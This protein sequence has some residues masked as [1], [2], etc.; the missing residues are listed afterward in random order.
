MLYN[1]SECEVRRR[2]TYVVDEGSPGALDTA[3]NGGQHP[4]RRVDDLPG[5]T[6]PVVHGVRLLLRLEARAPLVTEKG[7]RN[8]CV[9]SLKGDINPINV[10]KRVRTFTC[11]RGIYYFLYLID[12][13]KLFV[14][15]RNLNAFSFYLTRTPYVNT[16]DS[17]LGI[18][19]D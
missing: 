18:H 1:F 5:V 11:L 14:I 13:N 7:V 9:H 17:S 19:N 15:R 4:W 6:R 3:H 10:E 8:Q 12:C 2:T 16:F